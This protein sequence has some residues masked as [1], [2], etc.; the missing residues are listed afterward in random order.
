M[1]SAP[2]LGGQLCHC[3]SARPCCGSSPSL[4]AYGGWGQQ[5]AGGSRRAASSPDGPGRAQRSLAERSVSI[6]GILFLFPGR[7]DLFQELSKVSFK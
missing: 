7:I 3:M 4:S 6:Q 5:V 2:G 1:P